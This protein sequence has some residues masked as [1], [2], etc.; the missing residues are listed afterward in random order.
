M[1]F[2]FIMALKSFSAGFTFIE[3]LVVLAIISVMSS[4]VFADFSGSEAKF[5]LKRAGYQV[6][7]DIRETEGM[8]LSAAGEITCD[9]P[10]KICGFGLEFNAIEFP[11]SY[12]IF[13]DCSND[14]AFNNY[15]HD[16]ND[17]DVRRVF[18]EKGIQIQQLS[19]SPL[20]I[21]FTAPDPTVWINNVNWGAE[22]IITLKSSQNDNRTVKVNSVG[23]VELQ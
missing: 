23:R 6:A 18:L 4:I 9:T 16:N 12:L 22:A 14:C 21:I 7:Q 17:K 20:N 8:A 19:A 5:A 2:E 15:E 3:L 13:V 1:V 10:K 11:A